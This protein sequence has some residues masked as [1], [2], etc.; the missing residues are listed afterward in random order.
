MAR[1]FPSEINSSPLQT[2]EGLLITSAIRD[3][4]E[5]KRAEQRIAEQTQQLHEANRELRHLSSRI[6][7]SETK[8]GEG[9]AASCMTARANIWRRSR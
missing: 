7:A 8:S 6:V 3:I 1:R 5:R 9:L 2:E 4:S